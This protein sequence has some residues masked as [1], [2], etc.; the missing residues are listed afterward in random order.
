MDTALLLHGRGWNSDENWFPWLQKELNKRFLDIYTPNLPNT[1]NP[2]LEEQ[3]DYINVYASDFKDW[4]YIIAHSLWCQ[5]T[6]KFIEE[7]NIK[8]SIII[9]VAP[10]YPWLAK[11]LGKKILW[12]NYEILDKYFDIEIDFK[13]I[14]TLNNK[15]Y[16]FLSDND[17][18]INMENAKLYYKKLNNVEFK[19]FKNKWHFNQWAWIL[20]LKE[21]MELININIH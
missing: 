2:I 12:N 4:W 8:N 21:I 9:F 18:F 20:E 16:I 3:I 10:S 1:N 13:K 15:Y 5:L 6:M 11:K 7:N 14:N 19:E 17:P